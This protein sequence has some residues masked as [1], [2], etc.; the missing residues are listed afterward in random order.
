MVNRGAVIVRYKEPFI[1]WI[2]EADPSTDRSIVTIQNANSER[3]VYLISDEDAENIEAWIS[4]NF[5]TLF[6]NELEGWYTDESLWP[7]KRDL[8]TFQNW[9][10]VECHSLIFDTVGEEIYDDEI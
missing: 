9:C 4:A 3:T 7:K 2:N 1:R 6:E 8:Q 5:N 10:E